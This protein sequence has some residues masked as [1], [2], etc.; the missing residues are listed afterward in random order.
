MRIGNPI[1]LND[2][3]IKDFLIFDSVVLMS[4]WGTIGLEFIG[5]EV[6][7][8]RQV[9]GLFFLC[10]LPGIAVLRILRIHNLGSS[11]TAL[12]AVGSSLAILMTVGVMTNTLGGLVGIH[13]SMSTMPLLTVLSLLEVI[14]LVLACLRDRDFSNESILVIGLKEGFLLIFLCFVLLL[15]L[16]GTLF[17]NNLGSNMLSLSV[18]LLISF[19]I[20]ILGNSRWIPKEYFPAAVFFISASLLFQNSLLSSYVWGWDIHHE[21]YLANLVTQESH[22]DYSIPYNTNGMLSIVMLAPIISN[23][24]SMNLH[25]VFKVAYPLI[26]CFVP[27]GLFEMYRRRVS[28]DIAVMSVLLSVSF[29]VFYTMMLSLARQEIGELFFVLILILLFDSKLDDYRRSILL[30]V[31][32]FS[33][34]VSHY[35][36]SY[37]LALSAVV[38]LPFVY[39]R[40]SE[41][42]LNGLS[43]ARAFSARFVAL[44]AVLAFLWYSV[45]SSSSSVNSAVFILNRMADTFVYDFLNPETSEGLAILTV[46]SVSPLH[47]LAKCLHLA[48]QALIGVGLLS[49]LLKVC[50]SGFDRV[51]SGLAVVSFGVLVGAI[52]IPYLGSSLGT[53]RFYHIGLFFLAP[54]ALFGLQSILRLAATSL[55]RRSSKMDDRIAVRTFSMLLAVFLLFNSGFLYEVTGDSPVSVALNPDI[56]GPRFNEQESY[57]TQ[58][59]FSVKGDNGVLGDSYRWLLLGS[60]DWPN[61]TILPPDLN[62][63]P[64]NSYVFLGTFNIV[65][66]KVLVYH[67]IGVNREYVYANYP[68]LEDN[69]CRI[70]DNGGAEILL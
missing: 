27:L 44:F 55:Q 9:V 33:L 37:Y 64:L 6:P 10:Y 2:W 54:F 24:C 43:E 3:G 66:H 29:W 1:T 48:F 62:E 5:F 38:V 59:L 17:M 70:F 52:A 63:T 19:L 12:F 14:L 26:F 23:V 13:D 20:V 31:F 25:F 68:F 45:V 34:V 53:G 35:G 30:F 46:Q 41:K 51:Y 67:Q 18:L 49:C 22:W 39:R 36:L 40:M 11:L 57:A 50:K 15:A 47:L 42:G 69:R 60:Y 28:S 56:D 58:W 7:Y 4:L 61:V 8:L 16:T 65:E 32:A 21:L